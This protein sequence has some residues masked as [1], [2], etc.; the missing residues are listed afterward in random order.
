MKLLHI[1]SSL[2]GDKSVSR[3]LSHAIAQ[4][5]R[6]AEPDVRVTYRDLA[7]AVPPQLTGAALQVM[8][9][10]QESASGQ[11]AEDLRF[12]QEMLTEFLEADAVVIGAP[13]YNFS[14]PTQLK[15]W[16]D[17]LAQPGR[18]LP[19]RRKARAASLATSVW[20][21][22]RRAEGSTATPR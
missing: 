5:L 18:P 15:A 9:F 13:M 6:E 20:S 7:T 16:L 3:K 1:D 11:A 22:R 10:G 14:V 2:L 21:S 12:M 8:K 17:A 19:I 4:A